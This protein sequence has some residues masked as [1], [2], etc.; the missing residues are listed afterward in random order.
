MAKSELRG[1][2]VLEQPLHGPRSVREDG[3]VFPPLMH[4]ALFSGGSRMSTTP[5][6][7]TIYLMGTTHSTFGAGI[8]LSESSDGGSSW[9]HAVLFEPPS[10]CSYSTGCAVGFRQ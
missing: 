10:G 1:C 6:A 5:R 9:R 8:A 4:V 3:D 7:D 2:A